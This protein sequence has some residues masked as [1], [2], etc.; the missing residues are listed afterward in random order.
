MSLKE[1]IRKY[2]KT[3]GID[4]IGFLKIEENNKEVLDKIILSKRLSYLSEFS[5]GSLE[6]KQTLYYLWKMQNFNC[7][8]SFLLQQK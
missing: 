8:F 7:C 1:E 3:I 2:S 6:E 5:K 4:D